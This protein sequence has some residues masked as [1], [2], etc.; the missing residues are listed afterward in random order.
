MPGVQNEGILSE[1]VFLWFLEQLGCGQ[2]AS[3]SSC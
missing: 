1:K 3:Y 2:I